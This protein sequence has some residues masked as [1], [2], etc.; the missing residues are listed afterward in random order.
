MIRVRGYK[1]NVESREDLFAANVKARKRQRSAPRQWTRGL[2]KLSAHN[3]RLEREN[4]RLLAQRG[5]Y[6]DF[7]MNAEEGFLLVD[8]NGRIA[9][10]NRVAANFLGCSVD[11]LREKLLTDFLVPEQ[12]NYF[13]NN[14][15]QETPSRIN[16]RFTIKLANRHGKPS[17]I[18]LNVCPL[19]GS[20]AGEPL[21]RIILREITGHDENNKK[22]KHSEI[23]PSC[24]L[25]SL[26]D[27]L[28]IFDIE[29]NYLECLSP[30]PSDLL[31]PI[32]NLI[33]RNI[34]EILPGKLVE[35]THHHIREAV[36][37]GK[38]QSYHYYLDL[39]HG[40]QYYDVRM[41]PCGTG[42]V[43]SM[44]RNITERE[45]AEETLRRRGE[46][47]RILVETIPYGINEIDLEGTIK[48]ANSA[49]HNMHGYA[50]G[51]LIGTSIFDLFATDALR[52]NYHRMMRRILRKRPEHDYILT[53]NK[54]C[55]GKIITLKVDWNYKMNANGEVVGYISV[56]TDV[57]E[58]KKAEKALIESEKKHRAIFK[59]FPD[60][61]FIL[62]GQGTYLDCNDSNPRDL[63]LPR[64]ELIGMV[65][66]DALPEDAARVVMTNIK[67]ALLSGE[68]QRYEFNF[69]IGK[70][71]Q[72]FEGLMQAYGPNRVLSYVCNI[73]D[74]KNKEEALR[75]SEE[76][77]NRALEASELG[78]W[79]YDRTINSFVVDERWAGMLGFAVE[80]IEPTFKGWNDRIHP[81]DFRII[82]R[83]WTSQ[84]KGLINV[85]EF[86]VRMQTKSGDWKWIQGRG[87]A[88]Q[89]DER[90]RILRFT[91]THKDIDQQKRT[92]QLLAIFQERLE[93]ALEASELG[94]WDCQ[95]LE[96]V[97]V[98]DERWA[99]MLGYRVDEIKP[100][101]SGW[102]D[103]VHTDDVSKAEKVR[104]AHLS[105]QTEAMEVDLRMRTK[106]GQWKWIHSHGKIVERDK[107]GN[108]QRSIGTIQD[109][110]ERKRA[111]EMLAISQ[112][113]L[114]RALDASELGLW[115][116]DVKNKKLIID[117]RWASMLGYRIE[118]IEPSYTGWRDLLHPDDAKEV[119]EAWKAHRKGLIPFC[120]SEVRM[121]TKSGDWKWIQSRGKVLKRDEQGYSLRSTGTHKDITE[122]K[123][124]EEERERLE[125]H[126][127]QS[128]KM[129]VIGTLAGG[130]AHDFNNILQP[131]FGYLNIVLEDIPKD[132]PFREDLEQVYVCARRARELVRQILIFS[133]EGEQPREP[134]DLCPIIRETFT[135][136]R[137]VVYEG[138]EIRLDLEEKCNSVLGDSTQLSQALLNLI[139]NA[140]MAIG[141]NQG[142]VEI[143]LHEVQ[144]EGGSA[145]LHPDLREGDYLELTVRDNGAG[146]DEITKER[147][148]EP[149]FTTREIGEGSGLGLSVAQ[150]VVKSHGGAITVESKLGKGSAFTIFLPCLGQ[151]LENEKI[152]PPEESLKGSER[153]LLVDNEEAITKS[154]KAS[155]E[156]LGYTV[157]VKNSSVQAL[158][159][160]RSQ[161]LDFDLAVID[162]SMPR[163]TGAHLTREIVGIHPDFPV[164][165]I[166]G[167][168]E[169]LTKKEIQFLGIR[170]YLGKP[171][172]V[173]E[174]SRTIRGLF[175]KSEMKN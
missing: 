35:L 32:E 167:L 49:F 25:E 47:Y 148:F 134:V 17:R 114:E 57:T 93:R 54:T 149:F 75:R 175:P 30:Y 23:T 19:R 143:R 73:T 122:Q 41:I 145:R 86:E 53:R 39:P 169:F 108:P 59:S 21:L 105:G 137:S 60:L 124:A 66:K 96:D 7:F 26:P 116:Y 150:G 164:L 22:L 81:D 158:E 117:E 110:T 6:A 161:P 160:F 173:A 36:E 95:D 2:K 48:Q 125:A 98:V 9:E 136:L 146:M 84:Q 159:L 153:I 157:T 44:I 83:A 168:G 80:E 16:H 91:G 5:Y 171:F 4:K 92:E 10:A 155:L 172:E 76:R 71:I 144:L 87:N 106:S 11:F 88:V 166:T 152:P 82:K 27:L 163:M 118:D 113:R 37:T 107:R 129:E 33:G 115:D 140:C 43:L 13:L 12:R 45:R 135:L 133:R 29:G 68:L 111:E 46:D 61:I 130:I 24:I 1:S 40:R 31:A 100:N 52:R 69:P 50:D 74:R 142:T 138:I 127:R 104:L 101:N 56:V 121:R 131:I 85:C 65:I 102:K 78:M 15:H 99:G 67:T 109:I 72:Y 89:W 165:L 147:V 20:T 97:M 94:L 14:L 156:R 63:V 90:G 112:E 18:E 139:T 132:S 162:Q 77:L 170:G 58:Q 8:E 103:L 55:D 120:E 79:N 38:I 51:E 70:K 126:L 123:K 141:K 151:R 28:F 3:R 62:D 64:H 119:D 34:S 154:I 128:Q 174:L 42:K